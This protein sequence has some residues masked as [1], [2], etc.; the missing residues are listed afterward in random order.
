MRMLDGVRRDIFRDTVFGYLFDVPHLQ[1]DGL[2]FHKM[3]L[4]QIWSDV[5]LSPDK[6]KRLYFRVGDT[7]MVCGSEEFCLITDFNFGEY[8]KNIGKKILLRE[9][10]FPNYTNSSVKIGDLKSFILN[11]PFLK[12][13]DADA[14]RNKWSGAT[15][16]VFF[17]LRIL[18]ECFLEK[19]IN[20]RVPQDWFFW[21]RIW[22]YGTIS[23]GVVIYEILRMMTL[24]IHETR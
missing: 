8:P 24:R 5:I 4:H 14:V 19:E 15:R 11:Q 21:L 13:D 20:D 17:L 7:K 18:C 22:M 3:F 1:G 12:V 23:L 6:I 9:R 2:L 10:L 16:L